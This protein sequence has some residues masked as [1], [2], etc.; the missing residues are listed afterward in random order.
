MELLQSC[1]KVK[2]SQ[3]GMV[4]GP[5]ASVH[6]N[7]E[8]KKQFPELDQIP[9]RSFQ[10][11]AVVS[12]GTELPLPTCRMT[13]KE[14]SAPRSDVLTSTE[15]VQ[16]P[17][18]MSGQRTQLT[19]NASESTGQVERREGVSRRPNGNELAQALTPSPERPAVP[20]PPKWNCLCHKITLVI[21]YLYRPI[22]CFF[23]HL[24]RKQ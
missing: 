11:E 16:K 3:E 1:G 17:E 23:P 2:R 10:T 6:Q 7:Q 8:R 18:G 13:E 14:L 21:L 15:P 12:P 5:K 4:K 9:K 24:C 22:H 19:D 20:Q